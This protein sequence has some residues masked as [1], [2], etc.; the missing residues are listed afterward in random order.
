MNMEDWRVVDRM[1]EDMRRGPVI[2]QI[3]RKIVG[4]QEKLPKWWWWAF[5]R[6]VSRDMMRKDLKLMEK[7]GIFFTREGLKAKKELILEKF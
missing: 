1:L 7:Q 2:S 5:P 3:Y 6:T 4:K